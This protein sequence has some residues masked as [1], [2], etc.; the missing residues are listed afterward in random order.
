MGYSAKVQKTLSMGQVVD[1]ALIRLVEGQNTA[2]EFL[3]GLAAERAP[4][5]DNGA[6]VAS[7]QVVKATDSDESADV[8]FDTAYAARW[9]ED[10]PLVDSLGRHYDGDSNF[11][12]GRQSHYVTEPA[13][14]NKQK[15]VDIIRKKATSG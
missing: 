3:L 8:V 12:N 2:A 11:Q 14:Q 6:L 4:M 10:Q 13:E 1:G 9:H 7:G 15:I 5:D